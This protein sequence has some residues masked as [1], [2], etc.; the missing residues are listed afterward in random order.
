MATEDTNYMECMQNRELSWLKF[1]ERVLLEAD[2]VESP[3]LERLKFISIFTTNLDEFFMIRVGSLT[4]SALFDE[5]YFDNKTGQTAKAQLKAIFRAT[6]P[7]YEVREKTFSSVMDGLKNHDI[8]LLK[9]QDLGPEELEAQRE[10]FAYNVMPLL[11]PQIIDQK[12]PFPHLSNKRLHIAVTLRKKKDSVF[13]LIAMPSEL[14]RIV[15]LTG[16]GCRFVLLEDMIHYFADLAFGIYEV[17]EKHIIAVTRNA[18]L[19]MEDDLLDE[20]VDYRLYMK[21][22]LKKRQRLSPVR[23]EMSGTSSKEFLKF[24]CEKLALDPS[25]VFYTSAPLDLSFCLSMRQIIDSDTYSRLIW[26]AHVPAETMPADK[27]KNMIR[28]VYSG[29]VLLSYPYESMSP[30]SE[31]I[32]QAAEDPFVLS[33]KI[34]LYRIDRHSKLAEYLI[35]AAENGKEIL[36]I[37][38]LRARFDEDNNIEW[39][40]RLEQAGCRVIY[41]MVGY[42]VHSKICLITRKEFGKIQYVTQICTGNYN[43]ITARLYTDLSLLTANQDIGRD[44]AAFFTNMML[45]NLEGIYKELWVAPSSYKNNFIRM[46]EEEKRKAAEGSGGSIIIKCNSL[47]DKEIIECLAEASAAGVKI[48]ILLRGIC[49]LIPGIQG[50]TE[51]ISIISIVGRFLEHSRVF[52]FGSGPDKKI[53]ISSADLMTR[54]TQRRVETA[55]PI[56]DPS[57]RDAIYRMLNTSLSDNTHAW[58]QHP[59]GTYTLR[60]PSERDEGIDSQ[61]VFRQEAQ[62]SIA[63]ADRAD[64][65]NRIART[66]R[67][68]RADRMMDAY[69]ERS[70]TGLP[71][72]FKSFFRRR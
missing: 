68:D 34:T 32:R 35:R 72:F 43:E 71:G 8:H 7:L 59:D 44:A 45:G 69:E 28:T 66:D 65:A 6:G 70:G 50:L 62:D 33:V 53:Y 31:L 39:A 52:C 41:G 25:Q 14:E 61:E 48:T 16:P 21:D 58:D 1:N 15:L 54:N 5:K 26:P 55:C 22:M 2:R 64:R 36:V 18:D 4:D 40:H 11:S 12:H 42:K 19:N 56:L 60:T 63:G 67:T 38:E 23:L 17:A 10:Y 29:D 46:A 9:M 30:T 27:K 57:A 3:L 13:G 49:C 20:G 37:M 51:N 24:F 47:T